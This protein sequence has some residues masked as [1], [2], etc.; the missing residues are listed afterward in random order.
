MTGLLDA[1][2]VPVTGPR[3]DRLVR[4]AVEGGRGAHDYVTLRSAGLLHAHLP[5]ARL[6]LF[7]ESGHSSFLDEPEAYLET[8]TRFLRGL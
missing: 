7:P 6:V 4:V 5:D 2:D 8:V 3:P 1:A